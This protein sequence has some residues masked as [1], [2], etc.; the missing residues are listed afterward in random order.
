[1]FN[2]CV[3]KCVHMNFYI[4]ILLRSFSFSV[5]LEQMAGFWSVWCLRSSW[6]VCLEPFESNLIKNIIR[7]LLY[8][9]F[10]LLYM[11]A[12]SSLHKWFTFIHN[13][14]GEREKMCLYE[15]FMWNVLQKNSTVLCECECVRAVHMWDAVLHSLS[16]CVCVCV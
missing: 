11:C 15:P 2:I 12:L 9:K 3:C 8:K 6:I 1:M 4:D 10:Y 13:Y 14:I 7:W 5:Y 16:V